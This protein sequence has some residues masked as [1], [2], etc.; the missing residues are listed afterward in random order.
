MSVYELKPSTQW[1]ENLIPTRN[2]IFNKLSEKIDDVKTNIIDIKNDLILKLETVQNTAKTALKI[3]EESKA[4]SFDLK[5]E[6][7]KILNYCETLKTE[8]INLKQNVNQLDNYSRRNNLVIV[9]IE[10]K[11]N[12]Q[13]EKLVR[14]FFKDKLKLDSN[15]VNQMRI[16]GCHRHGKQFGHKGCPQSIIV[17]FLDYNDRH[18]VWMAKKN[19]N[20]KTLSINE[21]FCG[22]T[23]FKRR[24]LYPIY[25]AAKKNTETK[26]PSSDTL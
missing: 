10:E 2:N 21:H 11:D 1:G 12:Y 26:S 3:A 24:K 16:V 6:M 5:E 7:N 19:V 18:I 14:T 20:D 4:I 8:N 15:S 9:G 17:R 22:D 23:E 25:R 13:C